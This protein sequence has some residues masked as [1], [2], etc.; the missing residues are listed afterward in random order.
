MEKISKR[1]ID[2]GAGVLA[3]HDG[4][5]AGFALGDGRKGDAG[6]HDS[7]VEER[8]GEVHGATAVADDDGGDGGFALWGGVAAYVEASVGELLLEVEGVVPQALDAVGFGFED[9]EGG[10]A[11]CGDRGWMRGGEEEGAGA[12]VEIVDEVAAAADIAAECADCLGQS[13]DLH[14]DFVGARGS[15]RRSRDHCGRGRRSRGRRRPS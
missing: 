15:D 4:A 10:D 12:V 14:V 1:L 8:A 13:A 5:N 9:V 7:G 6:G 3:G 11:G 2:L